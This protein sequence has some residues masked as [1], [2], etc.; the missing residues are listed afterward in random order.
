M[1]TRR[2]ALPPGELAARSAQVAARL[3]AGFDVARWRTV[4]VFLPLQRRQELDMDREAL[5]REQQQAALIKRH[6]LE[7]MKLRLE[8]AAPQRILERGYAC[9]LDDKGKLVSSAKQVQ[10]GQNVSIDWADGRASACITGKENTH[11]GQK[12]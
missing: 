7:A 12:L 5:L 8:G 6:G 9:V 3:F 2:R 4:H 11:G 1:L 10:P